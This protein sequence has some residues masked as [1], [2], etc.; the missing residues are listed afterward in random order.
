MSEESGKKT[1][2]WDFEYFYCNDPRF[3]A[4]SFWGKDNK[5]WF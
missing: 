2:L 3:P 5:K 4:A 1:T